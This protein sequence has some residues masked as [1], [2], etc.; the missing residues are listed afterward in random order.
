MPPRRLY[1]FA[2]AQP[3]MSAPSTPTPI[4]ARAK[5]S[6]GS[7]ETPTCP[8]G[9]TGITIS[10]TR[11]GISATAGASVKIRRSAAAGTTSSFRA[12]FPPSATSCAQPWKPPAYIGPS[13]PCMCAITLCSAWPTSSGS[14]R[15][16][17]TTSNSLIAMIA[18][19]DIVAALGGNATLTPPGRGRSGRSVLSW[20]S[21]RDVLRGLLGR[22]VL[23][24][25]LVGRGVLGRGVLGRRRL[26]RL[27]GFRHRG[28]HGPFRF[29]A[30]R[31]D[32]HFRLD[33]LFRLDGRL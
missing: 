6:P 14:T 1:L 15:N 28:L 29:R 23:G 18:R 30:F 19:S 32:G 5:N 13:R 11:Y 3:A 21:G 26:D 17:T 10:T 12:N 22:G 31:L 16:A 24:R 8:P 2:L 27:R 25:G 7:I 20:L 9:P 4:I 33:W